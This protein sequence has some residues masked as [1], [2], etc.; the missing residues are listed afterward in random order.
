MTKKEF[1]K[2]LEESLS[3]NMTSNEVYSQVN[4]YEDYINNEINN[5][6]TENEVLE[7]L[8][9]PTLIAKT[10]KQVNPT[11]SDNIYTDN[12]KTYNTNDNYENDKQYTNTNYKRYYDKTGLG[13]AL[14]GIIFLIIVFA[15]LRFLGFIVGGTFIFFSPFSIIFLIIILFN[16]FRGGNKQ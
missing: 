9:D 14:F 12:N 1:I 15:L 11:S 2:K 3:A 5:G 7:E 6:K 13:C 4:Y 10:I 16:I 8:G